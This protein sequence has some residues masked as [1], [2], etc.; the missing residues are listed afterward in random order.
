MRPTAKG[1]ELRLVNAD[2]SAERLLWQAERDWGG[3]NVQW[4]PDGKRIVVAVNPGKARTRLVA[5]S[6][7]DG[8]VTTLWEGKDLSNPQ[9]SPDGKSAVGTRRVRKNPVA[10]E[11]RL[12]RLEDRSDVLLFEA[13]SVVSDPEWTPDGAGVVFLSDR[14]VPGATLDL[15]LLRTSGGKP[16]GIP[17]LVKTGLGEAANGYLT[18]YSE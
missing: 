16:L 15:W 9:I 13:Q 14:R 8:A 4:L 18:A 10:D 6:A 12:L 17:E 3:W 11:L 1:R 5:I 7:T 2:G